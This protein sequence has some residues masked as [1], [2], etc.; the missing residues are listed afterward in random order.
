MFEKI[1]HWL[2]KP[3]KTLCRHEWIRKLDEEECRYHLECMKCFK[4]TP[5]FDLT[6][7]TPHT[8]FRK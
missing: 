3:S 6:T 8:A 5:G 2:L 7:R 1:V 4:Q